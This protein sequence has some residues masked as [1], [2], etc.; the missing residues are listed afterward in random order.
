M[1]GLDDVNRDLLT[2]PFS[3]EEIKDVVFSLKHNSAPGSHL[4]FL[5]IMGYD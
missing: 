5:G 3:I 1:K 2:R 4:N